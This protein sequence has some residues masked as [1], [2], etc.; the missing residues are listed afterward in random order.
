MRGPYHQD[1][2]QHD[3]PGLFEALR[4]PVLQTGLHHQKLLRLAAEVVPQL[5]RSA[6][7]EKE[8]K[9]PQKFRHRRPRLPSVSVLFFF[10][11]RF[12]LSLYFLFLSIIFLFR[13]FWESNQATNIDQLSESALTNPAESS[14]RP[15][16]P[17]LH[18]PTPPPPHLEDQLRTN[19]P[20]PSQN[21]H[22]HTHTQ[23]EP[24]TTPNRTD[25]C[26]V[27]DLVFLRELV[28]KKKK[29]KWNLFVRFFS[30]VT[31]PH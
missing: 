19:R 9:K 17:P 11:R 8:E 12:F 23:R 22:T 4:L 31:C 5:T 14:H 7:V 24:Q 20:I 21:T 2:W 30:S 27:G 16:L 29:R 1:R 28:L 15:S 13:K 10:R 6:A 25:Q 18:F 3:L 26:G